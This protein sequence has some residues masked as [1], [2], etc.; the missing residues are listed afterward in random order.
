MSTRKRGNSSAAALALRQKNA[1]KS[2][3]VKPKSA[4]VSD[5]F[6][7]DFLNPGFDAAAFL[8]SK[9]PPL[10]G[11]SVNSAKASSKSTKDPVSLADLSTQAQT[12]V[13]QLNS[14]TT[15]LST[16]LTQLADDILRSG[17]R[18]AYEVELLRGETLGFSETLNETLQDDIKKF[19]PQGTDTNA[20]VATRPTTSLEAVPPSA[21][22]PSAADPKTPA[23]PTVILGA[24]D[25]EC[26]RQLQ[27]LTTVRARLQSVIKT[28]GD[29]MEFVFPPSELSVGS[30]FLSVSAPEPG[31]Q[32]QSSEDKG[33]EVLK[34]LREEI[35]ELLDNTEDPVVGIEKAAQRIEELKELNIVWK[36][37]AE[38]K[39]RL[40]FIDSLAKMVE[41][42]HEKML[43]D[44][45]A[46][47]AAEKTAKDSGNKA[48]TTTAAQEPGPSLGYAG[49][50]SQFQKIR[51]AV[52]QSDK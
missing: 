11:A 44:M 6:L 41:E 19:V 13:T 37:T 30:S 48:S 28:F 3:P 50:M 24:D 49:F 26:I 20:A 1:A 33:Q 23:L 35:R 42:R 4:H 40:K 45:E 9:L 31:S 16:T 29:A 2:E 25:P 7:T 22:L 36:G 8:N 47:A 5:S 15:R 27:T 21:A 38:E 10:K 39:G 18:L 43:R 52:K 51:E 46:K 34:R 12:A 32:D 14:H 17:S